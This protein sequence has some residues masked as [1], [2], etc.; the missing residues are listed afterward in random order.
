MADFLEF[1]ATFNFMNEEFNLTLC[2]GLSTN[3]EVLTA[4][5]EAKKER[6]EQDSGEDFNTEPETEFTCESSD[7][8]EWLLLNN[9][10]DINF[11]LLTQLFENY[12]DYYSLDIYEAAHK[13]DIQLCDVS[14]CYSGEFKSDEDFAQDIAEQLGAIDKNASWP[15]TC[16]DWEQ[17]AKELMYDYVESN[18]HYFRNI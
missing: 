18:G 13:A 2:E 16:I 8:P 7:L 4:L 15:Q 9:D 3:D 5:Q 12:E 10:Q 11:E 14:E 17:A 6:F 1:E